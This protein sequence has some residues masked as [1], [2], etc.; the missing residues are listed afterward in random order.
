ME[1]YLINDF[2]RAVI[3]FDENGEA[4]VK[5]KGEKEFKAQKGSELVFDA[6]LENKHISKEQYD[7]Y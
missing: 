3:R 4:Y 7:N 5:F 6:Y 2:E 1:I